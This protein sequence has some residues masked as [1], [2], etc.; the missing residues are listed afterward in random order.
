NLRSR[1][2][3]VFPSQSKLVIDYIPTKRNRN[4]AQR[5]SASPS[6]TRMFFRN[7][8]E[9][10]NGGMGIMLNDPSPTFSSKPNSAIVDRNPDGTARSN[11]RNATANARL[12]QGPA[13]EITMFSCSG[14]RGLYV[15]SYP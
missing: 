2:L 13:A 7:I 8:L 10:S 4:I 1:P 11:D 14:S 12:I 9:P 3:I 5:G 15:E 6:P